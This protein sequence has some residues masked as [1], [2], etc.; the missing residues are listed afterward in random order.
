MPYLYLI[1]SVVFGSSTSILGAFFNRKNA[2]KKDTSQLYTLLSMGSVFV[3][4]L[5]FFL[6][7]RGINWKVVPYSVLFALSYSVC[8]LALVQALKTG[9]IVLTSL[10]L[11]LSLIGV[12]VWGFLFWDAQFTWLVGI[13]LLLVALSLWLCL[14]SV[15]ANTEGKITWKWLLCVLLVF[16]GNAGCSIAQRTQQI[17]FD[18]QY[19][20][21]LMMLATGLSVLVCLAVYL[22]S[23]RSDSREILRVSWYFPISAGVCNALLNL[24]V[25]L[26]SVPPASVTLSSSV[27]YPVIA[28][29]GLILNTLFSVLVFK[30][31][32]RWWQWLGVAIGIVAVGILNVG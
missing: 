10:I 20:N 16:V 14:Y 18:G 31:K 17:K 28:V 19:G 30:E 12:T 21:F 23:D 11:Q 5:V 9:P 13:G 4:W 29:G 8:N 7:D 3:F 2:E 22:K 26:L 25:M 27:V 32:M 15:K 1:G 24:L 6:F